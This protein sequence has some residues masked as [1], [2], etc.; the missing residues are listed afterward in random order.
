MR[1]KLE[2]W[3]EPFWKSDTMVDESVLMVP[4]AKGIPEAP[5]LFEPIRIVT[6][7]SAG[8]DVTYREGADWRY[9]EGRLQL[10]R[11]SLAPTLTREELY[12]AGSVLWHEGHWFHERHLA[13]TYTHAPDAWRGPIPAGEERQRLARTLEKL[14]NGRPLRIVL[15]GDSIAEGYNASGFASGEAPVPPHMPSWGE[16]VAWQLGKRYGTEIVF[17]N[18]ALA[19][20]DSCWGARYARKL[21]ARERPDLV[22][23]AFGM[24]DG[25]A[26]L[27]PEAF[28]ANMRAIMNE[29]KVGNLTA[30]F[31]LV[32]PMLPNPAS[33]AAGLQAAYAEPLRRLCR[34]EGA[35]FV[36]MTGV[37]QELLKRKPY[38]D[39]TGN[40]IN[41]PNDYLIRWYAQQ[42]S[43]TLMP[44]DGEHNAPDELKHS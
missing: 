4:N 34:Q 25:S 12:P 28:I 17:R 40:H 20:K 33:S 15:Y 37:H 24:N 36:D 10:L 21:V 19:C 41:H 30:E 16:L 38:W 11:G 35:A 3:L 1:L 43:G 26:K 8:L 29:A 14:R 27:A 31:L 13:V 23:L 18:A 6:V 7:K 32:S 5:L 42:I 44:S 22:M 39:M 9:A 2:Q